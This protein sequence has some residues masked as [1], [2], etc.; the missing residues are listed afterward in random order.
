MQESVRGITNGKKTREK[1][2]TK[3]CSNV[4][5]INEVEQNNV[6]HSRMH[7]TIVIC[8]IWYL[9]CSQ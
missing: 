5:S 3:A 8:T 2:A 7:E 9:Q 6:H 1:V 4:M